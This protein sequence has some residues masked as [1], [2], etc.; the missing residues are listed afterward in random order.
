MDKVDACAKEATG[1]RH[2]FGPVPSRRFGR[3]LGVDLVPFKTCSLNCAFCEVGRTTCLTLKRA[4][5]VPIG[6]VLAELDRWSAAG[7]VTDFVTLAGSGEPTLHARFGEVLDW[8]RRSRRF[9]SALL[10]NGTLM[11]DPTVR[12]EARGADVVKLSLSAGD[13]ASFAR[14][15][16]P[17]PDL[18]FRE[19]VDAYRLFRDEYAGELWIEVFLVAGMN[20]TEDEVRRIA[21][22]VERIRP[23][24][25]HLN[26]V[27][28]P[29]AESWAAAVP[30]ERLRE[31]AAFFTPHGQTPGDFT[32]PAGRS[33]AGG[34]EA[35][36][37]ILR[38]RPCTV[39]QLAAV[40]GMGEAE[41]G[42]MVAELVGSGQA[43]ARAENGATYYSVFSH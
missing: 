36:A 16:R 39:A 7:G 33:P 6:E 23:D 1:Y 14:V 34:A 30:E 3:S 27:A 31:L 29:A 20:D 37:A 25:V 32:S 35:V 17:H 12:A 18:K 42:A 40:L 10:T 26:T 43:E 4:E 8:T 41:V 11:T 28:R 13:A 38:R 9:R 2:L 19:F 24:R 22:E 15:H 21:A 5:Y